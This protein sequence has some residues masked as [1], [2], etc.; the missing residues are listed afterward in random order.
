LIS[1]GIL[2]EP[3]ALVAELPL[4]FVPIK[5]DTI[6]IS[7]CSAA[8]PQLNQQTVDAILAANLWPKGCPIFFH[9]GTKTVMPI[10][11]LLINKIIDVENNIDCAYSI[12]DWGK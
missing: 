10:N 6:V 1:I 3:A 12:C 11:L 4:F 8:I 9:S 5:F 2:P 7:S